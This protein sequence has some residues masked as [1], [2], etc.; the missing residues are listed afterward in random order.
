MSVTVVPVGERHRA[1][2]ERLYAG[3]AAFY[4]VEQT[5]AMRERVWGWIH[6]PAHEVRG[7][8]AEDEGG[9]AVGLAHFR[10]F[11]RPL[12]ATVGGFLDD[13]FVSPEARGGRVADALIEALAEEGRRRGWSVIR[14]ITADD[15]YRGRGVYD[16]LATRTMWIT[17]DK[18][19][20]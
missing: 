4:K 20:G 13:L 7:F 9:R 5:Q 3:Y 16:R 6:D 14:W 12:S 8:V 18:K 11:A 1:D 19:P 2:W 15:N 17:Y 10:P